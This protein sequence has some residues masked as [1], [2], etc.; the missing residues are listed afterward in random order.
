M[1]AETETAISELLKSGQ[2]NPVKTW[3]AIFDVLRESKLAWSQKIHVEHLLVHPEN[4]GKTGINPYNAHKTG[5]LILKLGA[6]MGELSK[7]TC[8]EVSANSAKHQEQLNFNIELT[9]AANGL[10]APV[11]GVERFLTVS[12]SHTAAFCRA[13]LH[14]CSSPNNP[15]DGKLHK[16]H[17]V[18]DPQYKV[19][20]EEG[21]SWKVISSVA[22][23]RFPELPAFAAKALNAAHNVTSIVTELE[24][25]S[26]MPTHWEIENGMPTNWG[27]IQADSTSD[28]PS[29]QPYVRAISEWVRMY[30]G[31][32]SFPL[33]TFLAKFGK[34]F[35]LNR[36]LGQEFWNGVTFINFNSKDNMY[37]FIRLML[38]LLFSFIFSCVLFET[39]SKTIFPKSPI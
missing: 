25:A 10:L 28:H 3:N 4:R 39:K 26:R 30:G 27:Y 17:Y 36:L 31:G 32:K 12:S 18:V 22:S 33:V 7:S 9:E 1:Q 21:W 16:A 2:A 19:M 29:C 11:S 38:C 5:A 20:L 14:G 34:M 35:A 24:V 23:E 13:V 37:C 15:I 8:F 6:D